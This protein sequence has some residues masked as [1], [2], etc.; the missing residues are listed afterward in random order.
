MKSENI[1]SK[2]LISIIIPIYN[3]ASYLPRCL[4]SIMSQTFE[5]FE[6]LLIDDGSTD[7]SS[8]ICDNYSELDERIRIFHKANEGVSVARNLGLKHSYGRWVVFVDSDDY[9]DEKYLASLTPG[10]ETG[11]DL[12]IGN[13]ILDV[14]IG[15]ETGICPVIRQRGYYSDLGSLLSEQNL[16]SGSGP[17]AKL[18]D[19]DIIRQNDLR[20]PEGVKLGEDTCFF[21]NYLNHCSSVLCIS[22]AYYH[23]VWRIGSASQHK[24]DFN[25]EYSGYQMNKNAIMP[26]LRQNNLLDKLSD[27]YAHWV[28][29]FLHRAITSVKTKTDFSMI[30]EDDWQFFFTYFKPK[31]RK[32]KLDF[33]VFSKNRNNFLLINL[34]LRT[35]KIVRN[36]VASLNL[37][38]LMSFLRK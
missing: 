24:Y 35:I 8:Q 14:P 4:D 2:P 17:V 25:T 28:T 13:T 9:V 19:L 3:T 18:F 29:Y 15:V 7:E 5:D 16:T 10:I 36:T 33:R 31:T 34:Y 32:T 21:F 1:K 30:T 26:F 27:P 23:V 11:A 6:L 38:K 20:F 22:E 37:W 12:V